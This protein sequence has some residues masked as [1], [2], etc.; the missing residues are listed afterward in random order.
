MQIHFT[1]F[2]GGGV[3]VRGRHTRDISDKSIVAYV[4]SVRLFFVKHKTVSSPNDYY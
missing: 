4:S 1:K 3:D 2:Q